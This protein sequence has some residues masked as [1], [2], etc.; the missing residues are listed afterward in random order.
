MSAQQ[1]PPSR[2]LERAVKWYSKA[3]YL[4]STIELRKVIDKETADSPQNVER[5]QFFMGKAL[6]RLG[7]HSAADAAFGQV[8][9]AG[10]KHRYY[11]ATLKWYLALARVLPMAEVRSEI[12]KLAP[13][14]ADPINT[15]VSD[16]VHF[17]LVRLHLDRGQRSKARAAFARID[18]AS[19]EAARAQLAF[20]I[21]HNRAGRWKKAATMARAALAG[22][23]PASDR[24]RAQFE[25]GRAA[26]DDAALDAAVKGDPSLRGRAI[27]ERHFRKTAIDRHSARLAPLLY[28]WGCAADRP[29]VLAKALDEL[30][31]LITRRDSADRFEWVRRRR[32]RGM[33][34]AKLLELR[35][36]QDFAMVDSLTRQL[37]LYDSLDGPWRS[38]ALGS[39]TQQ[40]LELRKALAEADLGKRAGSASAAIKR[41]LALFRRAS[42]RIKPLSPTDCAPVV[43]P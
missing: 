11:A 36:A 30:E 34:A 43:K 9:A 4:S 27:V 35:L 40:E 22:A 2:T 3:D 15:D 5:A 37:A 8:V 20:A 26:D 10:A 33:L 14:A 7:L 28:R 19:A 18:N 32:S 39:D 31:P 13:R 38:T 25:L 12:L 6:H 1:K 42:R 21:D 23:L 16:E 17:T 41:E 24:A 29:A